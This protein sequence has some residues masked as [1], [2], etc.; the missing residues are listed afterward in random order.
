VNV[1]ELVRADPALQ[2]LGDL[3]R[4]GWQFEHKLNDGELQQIN[5]C[6]ATGRYVDG[7]RVRDREDAAGRRWDR[8]DGHVIWS[9]EGSLTEVIDALMS[10]PEPPTRSPNS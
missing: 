4:A 5:G 3:V 2:R 6:R 1:D 7:L 8:A 9:A 10:L